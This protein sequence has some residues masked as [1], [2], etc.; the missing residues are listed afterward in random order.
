[1]LRERSSSLMDHCE[2]YYVVAFNGNAEYSSLSNYCLLVPISYYLFFSVNYYLFFA[3][4]YYLF[5]VSV[6][7]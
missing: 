2:I 7:M 4:K 5:R 1:M 6:Y 3:I